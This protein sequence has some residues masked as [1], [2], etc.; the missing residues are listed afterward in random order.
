MFIFSQYVED[1]IP[2]AYA[3]WAVS[4]QINC[5]HS[6]IVFHWV[7]HFTE[8]DMWTAGGERE[9]TKLDPAPDFSF[10]TCGPLNPHSCTAEFSRYPQDCRAHSPQWNLDFLCFFPPLIS[11]QCNYTKT[12]V[13]F[14]FLIICQ[15]ILVVM[16]Q[17]E[18]FCL[19]LS[20]MWL[21]CRP[22]SSKIKFFLK[23][24]GV[25]KFKFKIGF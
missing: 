13:S 10:T 9:G 17:K 16:Y 7:V 21:E 6:W 19:T 5:W 4:Y 18:F 2:L 25:L 12:N 8:G 15:A 11:W 14:F 1:T 22:L 3:C 20:I 24:L 23:R